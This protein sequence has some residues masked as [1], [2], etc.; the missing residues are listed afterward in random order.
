MEKLSGCGIFAWK[1]TILNFVL[2][3][4]LTKAYIPK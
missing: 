1:T 3:T 2:K 4:G